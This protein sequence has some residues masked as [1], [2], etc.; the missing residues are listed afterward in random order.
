MGANS[1]S[2]LLHCLE[3]SLAKNHDYDH[4]VV[5]VV[6]AVVDGRARKKRLDVT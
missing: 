6:A 1:G 3:C 4:Q 2:N 5:A